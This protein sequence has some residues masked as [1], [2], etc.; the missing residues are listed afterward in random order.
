M[1]RRPGRKARS[2]DE[3]VQEVTVATNND[4]DPSPS[5][6]RW[7]RKKKVLLFNSPEMDGLA[8]Q[9]LQLDRLT[10][11]IPLLLFLFHFS[12]VLFFK[13]LKMTNSGS[14]FV[15]IGKKEK[16][17]WNKEGFHGESSR[18]AFPIFLYTMSNLWRVWM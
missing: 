13:L 1:E 7:R 8:D 12:A 17:F 4:L 2:E 14:S 3:E 10:S 16:A 9:I 15:N 11:E 5:E 6:L 18:M